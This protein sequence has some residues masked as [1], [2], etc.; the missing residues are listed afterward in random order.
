MM[1]RS[2][3]DDL[4]G[5][6]DGARAPRSPADIRLTEVQLT[7]IEGRYEQWIRFGQVAAE[8]LTSRHSKIVS[9]RPGSRFAFVRW[10]SNDFG[11][12]HSS[13]Q[14]LTAVAAGAPYSTLPFVRPGAEILLRV[15]GWTKVSRVLQAIDAV[16]AADI[17]ACDAS[18][19]HWRHVASRLAA[20][21]PFRTYT[22]ERHAAWL[23]REALGI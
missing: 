17:E 13:I 6:G 12:V 8:R 11:T 23:R 9:F 14:V 22:A 7:W 10:V 2:R 21:S 5:L 19:D 20:G 18:P 3:P 15:E 1:L 4:A 16:E